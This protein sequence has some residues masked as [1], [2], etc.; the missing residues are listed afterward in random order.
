MDRAGPLWHAVLTPRRVRP[1]AH[2]RRNLEVKVPEAIT[3]V[4]GL[5]KKSAASLDEPALWDDL[6]GDS[7]RYALGST[8][9]SI[10][11]PTAANVCLS[12][13]ERAITS[14]P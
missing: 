1:A 12:L 8:T 6:V 14:E 11:V 3:V 4:D 13:V 2:R 7:R 5:L 9:L 10:V